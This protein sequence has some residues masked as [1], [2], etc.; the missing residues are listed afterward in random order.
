MAGHSDLVAVCMT[1]VW[2]D[3][4]LNP[5]M[6]KLC[7]A[8]QHTHSLGHGLYKFT[9]L[10]GMKYQLW[11]FV[12]MNDNGNVDCSSL[13][14]DSQPELVSWS[15]GWQPSG[16]KSKFIW[17]TGKLWQWLWRQQQK[18]FTQKLNLN[19]NQHSTVRTARMC[20]HVTVNN[21]CT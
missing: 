4:D 21:G 2:E 12:I 15:K 8:L 14:V 20:E 5:T 3:P 11:G 19:L 6:A 17:W 16:A 18:P 10:C 1:A 9:A 13:L 7:T